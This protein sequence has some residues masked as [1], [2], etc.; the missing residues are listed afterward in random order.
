MRPWASASSLAADSLDRASVS[1]ATVG[2]LAPKERSAEFYGFFAIAGRTSSAVGPAV[3]GAIVFHVARTF[4]WS[5]TEAVLA[6]Q[7]A[8]RYALFAI[9]GFLILGGLMLTTVS[10]RAG[11]S[12][13][14]D[15]A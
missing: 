6:E 2:L 11:R 15:G 5:G 7:T 3:F 12:R 4:E 10:A 13:G 14:E 1:R 8:H 9:I